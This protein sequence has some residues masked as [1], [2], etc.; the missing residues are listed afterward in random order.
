MPFDRLGRDNAEDVQDGRNDVDRVVVLVADLA[1]SRGTGRPGD[2]AGIARPSVELVALPHLEGGVERHGP[3]GRIVVVGAGAAQLVDL[4]QILSQVVRD[5]VGELHF[6][7]RAVRS[8]FAAGAVVGDQHDQGVVQFAALLE[9]VQQASDVVV[10]V[11]EETGVHLGHP[12]EQA[13]LVRVEGRPR[14]GVVQG[15]ERLAVGAGA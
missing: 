6:I 11:G 7:D 1:P 5:A 15:R 13:S 3:A 9:G 2:D 12:G 4:G 14:S 8:A 10:G